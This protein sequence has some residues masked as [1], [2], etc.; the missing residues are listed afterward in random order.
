M[1]QL[2]WDEL[3]AP[4]PRSHAGL[5]GAMQL[6]LSAEVP[7]LHRRKRARE[8][9]RRRESYPDHEDLSWLDAMSPVDQD[10]VLR[11]RDENYD[12]SVYISPEELLE[13]LSDRCAIWSSPGSVDGWRLGNQA[14]L[15][16]WRS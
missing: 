15:A 11:Q 6:I 3:E 13:M 10:A 7:E 12:N 5:A 14:A 4:L 8:T 1:H 9:Q 16:C 2:Q